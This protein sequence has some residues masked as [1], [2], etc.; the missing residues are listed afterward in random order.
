MREM[1]LNADLGEGMGDDAA[2]LDIVTSANVACGAHAGSPETMFATMQMAAARGVAVGAHP[3]YADPA[4]FGRVVVP[5]TEAELERLVAH[6]VGAA[7]GIAAL[8][9]VRVSHVKAHGALYNLASE[10]AGVARAIARAVRAV[11]AGLAVLARAGSMAVG[12]AE[13][14]GLRGVHEIFADR[15]YLPDGRLMPR[16][17][18]GAVIHDAGVVT[19]RVLAMLEAG[20]VIAEGGVRL[21]LPMDSICVHGDTPGSV[22]IARALRTAL[23]A[24]GHGVRPFA[25]AAA[26]R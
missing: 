3:G 4:R 20:G 2:M 10:D 15:A 5:Q 22:G 9:G 11:D 21:A 7:I 25:G 18:P 8:A 1:D 6:Q 17:R 23:R 19:E 12:A 14:L 13:V 24:A 26:C 16:E